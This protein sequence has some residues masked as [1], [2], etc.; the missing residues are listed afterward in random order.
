MEKSINVTPL[1]K[2]RM[3]DRIL[4]KVREFM[5]HYYKKEVAHFSVEAKP[6]C[7]L[8]RW[9]TYVVGRRVRFKITITNNSNIVDATTLYMFESV[10]GKENYVTKYTKEKLAD[11]YNGIFIGENITDEGRLEYKIGTSSSPNNQQKA[12]FSCKPIDFRDRFAWLF[13]TIILSVTITK[14]W[15]SITAVLKMVWGFLKNLIHL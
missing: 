2:C 5:P 13:F 11:K 10:N 7:F 14:Y 9:F 4:H 3:I 15:D 12:I 6:L 8:R 1:T